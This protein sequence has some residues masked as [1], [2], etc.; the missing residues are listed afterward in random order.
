MIQFDLHLASIK[1]EYVLL[2]NPGTDIEVNKTGKK[3]LD[4]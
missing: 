4:T 2:L 1:F 3:C